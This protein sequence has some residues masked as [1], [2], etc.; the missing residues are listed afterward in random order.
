MIKIIHHL[1]L[2]L[3]H[4]RFR[5]SSSSWWF[6][7]SSG[8]F[9]RTFV[10]TPIFLGWKLPCSFGRE[11]SIYFCPWI[12]VI[13]TSLRWSWWVHEFWDLGCHLSLS[14]KLLAWTRKK[15]LMVSSEEKATITD[16]FT[17]FWS[18][19]LPIL[20]LQTIINSP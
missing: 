4:R 6:F 10:H 18:Y 8:R 12:R 11:F 17:L 9:S 5:V 3:L 15:E 16:S 1:I 7:S 2:L 20:L 13:S 14:G 19:F